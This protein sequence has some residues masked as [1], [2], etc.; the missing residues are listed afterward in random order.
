MASFSDCTMNMIRIITHRVPT[1]FIIVKEQ[2]EEQAIRLDLLIK[3]F[4]LSDRQAKAIGHILEHR[5]LTIQDF[6]RFFP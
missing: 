1:G 4:C 2:R 5:S 3:E 6:E